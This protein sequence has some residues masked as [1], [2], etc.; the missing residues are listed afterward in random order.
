MKTQPS[1]LCTDTEFIRRVYLDLTGLPPSPEDIRAFLDDSREI[2]VK[3]D[4][5]VDRLI[6]CPEYVDFWANKWA[7]LLQCNSKFLGSEGAELFRTWIRHEVEK[8]TPYDQFARE[9]LTASGS[10]RENPPASYWKILRTPTEAMENTTHLFLATRFNCNKCHDHPFE[11]WTQDQYYQT[12]AFFAQVSLKEDPASGDKKIAGTAVEGAQPLY[13]IVT[14]APEGEVKHDR[15]GK[16]TPPKFPFPAK[17]EKKEN[18]PRREELAAWITTPDNRYFA[19]SYANRIWGYLT[20]VGV[21][22]PLDDI[23]AGNPPSNPELLNHLTHEFVDSGFNV[24][25]M[26]KLICKSRTYQLSLRPTKWNEDDQINYSHAVARRLPAETLFDAVF[27]VT[28]AIPN[29]P[30]AKAGQRAAQLSD[31]GMDVSSGLLATLGRP[32]RQSACECERS[33][34]IRLGSVMALLSGPTVSSAINDPTNALAKLVE[35]EPDDRKLVNEVFLRVLN[36]P[37]NDPEI[38]KATAL[39]AALDKDQTT[40]TN[41]LGPLEVKMAP[42]IADLQRQREEAIARAKAELGTYDEN[43][44]FLRAELEKRREEQI[45]VARRELKDYEKLLPAQA[46]YW[47]SKNNLADLKTTWLTLNAREYKATDKKVKL[48][49][50]KDKSILVVG[51]NGQTDY[52]IVAETSLTNITGIM[53]EVLPDERLPKFGP[54]RAADGN[55]VLSEFDLKW[56][57]GTNAPDIVAKFA[58]ARADFSQKDFPV[59]EAIDGKIEA[60]KNGWAIGS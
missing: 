31:A 38:D 27:Q 20:G 10:N 7:D 41:E 44:K 3:R 32:A 23:R 42:V 60:G 12:A 45:V 29:I 21:I 48:T 16:V 53:L 13:E 43:T 2:R 40:L 33:S 39:I 15:T 14:N 57:E 35:S 4:A 8:N 6:G 17:Y 18:E 50:L 56:T 59:T 28:G 24:Q 11:R 26:M 37:A 36:R 51:A 5:V 54:G 9:I 58:D 34:D 30:G 1:E 55:F 25:H 19:S 47:E 46:A 22:E 49:K 52:R